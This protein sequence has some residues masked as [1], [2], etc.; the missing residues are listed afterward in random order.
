MKWMFIRR[1][2]ATGWMFSI[3]GLGIDYYYWKVCNRVGTLTP[4]YC[5]PAFAHMYSPRITLLAALSSGR[6]P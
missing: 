4:E 3:C 2:R 5:V 6:L 1:V